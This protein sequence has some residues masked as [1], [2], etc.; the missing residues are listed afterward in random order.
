MPVTLVVQSV[1][2]YS[3]LKPG[4]SVFE[5]GT[6]SFWIVFKP[7]D[8]N[9]KVSFVDDRG[10]YGN[11]VDFKV[12]KFTC[13]ENKDSIPSDSDSLNVSQAFVTAKIDQ[14]LHRNHTP[15]DPTIVPMPASDTQSHR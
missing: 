9:L 13:E 10:A 6:G 4:L 3:L 11:V 5:S 8:D 2:R 12:L 1:F 14:E 15:V 7:E